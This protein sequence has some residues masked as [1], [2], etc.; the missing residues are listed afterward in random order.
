MASHRSIAPVVATALL[1]VSAA[2]PGLA[3]ANPLLSG[4]GGPGTGSQAILG[5]ALLN[6]PPSSGGGEGGSS[7][8][9]GSA[10]SSAGSA[11]GGASGV[12]SS[13]GSSSSSAR[14]GRHAG[15]GSRSERRTST[16][17]SSG[18][19]AIVTVRPARASGALVLPGSDLLYI[20]VVGGVLALTGVLTR[21]LMRPP[22]SEGLGS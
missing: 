7:G 17:P 22:R 12:T 19:A 14:S 15:T 13:G 11:A 8:G 9:G 21:Q 16:G 1:A 2:A 3:S 6:G 5:A 4:Y 10:V 18:P 20:L